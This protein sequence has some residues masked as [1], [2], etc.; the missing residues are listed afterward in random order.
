M[1]FAVGK[2]K[3]V[4]LSIEMRLFESK[5]ERIART[6]GHGLG[7]ANSAENTEAQEQEFNGL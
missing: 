4:R 5:V 2:Y 6:A 7:L 1:S 3:G